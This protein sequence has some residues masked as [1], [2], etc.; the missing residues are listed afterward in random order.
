MKRASHWS[1]ARQQWLGLAALSLLGL[2]LVSC[3]V[4]AM[5]A[6][7]LHTRQQETLQNMAGLVAH[8]LQEK[9]PDAQQDGH[10]RWARLNDHFSGHP[11]LE[12]SIWNAQGQLLYHTPGQLPAQS[13]GSWDF[14]LPAP[15]GTDQ[16][17]GAWQARL[18]QD[19]TLDTQ[20]L[21]QL[22]WILL[23]SSLMG[24]AV[25]AFG[26]LWLIRRLLRPL[27]HLQKQVQ[28]LDVGQLAQRLGDAQQPQEL[29][30]LV[31]QFNALLQRIQAAYAQLD[32]FNADVAHELN[33]PLATL[34]TSTELALRK[35]REA[36]ALRELLGTQLEELQAISSMVQDMLFLAQADRGAKARRSPVTSLRALVQTVADYHEAA[37]SEAD[38]QLAIVGEASGG[39]DL[40]LLKRALSNLLGNASRYAQTGSQVSIYITPL[41]AEQV[42]LT[43]S[44][45]GVEIAPQDLPRIFDRLYRSDAART[46]PSS[47]HGLGLSIVAAVARMHDGSPFARSA[48]GL[49]EIG[50]DLKIR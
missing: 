3:V 34:I 13:A 42:R 1:L 26:G 14:A 9:M 15:A 45:F 4:Y 17:A 28:A 37:L 20:L 2:S 10:T 11:D 18:R 47:H 33:T 39:F 6:R 32:G 24:V 7:H 44:N 49:T 25:F 19:P 23:A 22:R 40:P 5:T 43:V 27:Q 41:G 21:Q 48:A 50:M 8:L 16:A 35:P 30:A 29:Q 12:L 38:L 36:P 46:Q 31:Q